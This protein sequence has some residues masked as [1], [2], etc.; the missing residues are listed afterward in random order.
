MEQKEKKLLYRKSKKLMEKSLWKVTK[1][2]FY[3]PYYI[4]E[5]DEIDTYSLS[6]SHRQP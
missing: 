4:S 3:D 2:F 1:D 6:Q 5:H